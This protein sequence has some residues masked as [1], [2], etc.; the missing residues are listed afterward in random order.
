MG[1]VAYQMQLPKTFNI[2]DIF[3]VSLLWLYTTDGKLQPSPL[4]VFKEDVL[5]EVECMISYEDRGFCSCL[6][7]VCIL[8]WL[9]YAL[10]HNSL[11]LES[12]FNAKILQEY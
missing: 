6:E 3:H 8:K 10:G 5:Y 9:G 12:N 7:K 1:N 4:P 11:V 2:Y